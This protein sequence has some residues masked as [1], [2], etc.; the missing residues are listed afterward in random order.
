MDLLKTMLVY[1]TILLTSAVQANPS[2]TPAPPGSIPSPTATAVITAAPTDVPTA[3]PSV[4]YNT[5][6]TGDRGEEV[7]RLQEA[8]KAKGYYTDTV[9]GAYGRNTRKAVEAFQAANGI[10]ADG[11][12]G[13][14]TQRL[15]FEGIVTTNAPAPAAAV[16]AVPQAVVT[17]TYLDET[18]AIVAQRQVTLSVSATVYAQADVLPAG[19]TLTG[20]TTVWINVS[21]G[22]AVPASVIFH[23]TGK[24][25][26]APTQAP[27]QAPSATPAAAKVNVFYVDEDGRLLSSTAVDMVASG[28]V[29]AQAGMVPAGYVLVSQ[30]SAPVTVSGGSASPAS[31]TFIYHSPVTQAPTQAPTLVP[32]QT[33][34]VVPTEVPTDVPTQ[35]PTQIPTEVPVTVTDAPQPEPLATAV[36]IVDGPTQEPFEEPTEEPAEEPAEEPTE[37]PTA[38]P[39]EA[40]TEEPVLPTDAPD[41][42]LATAVPVDEPAQLTVGGPIVINE[43]P[44]YISWCT[45]DGGT[46]FVALKDLADAAGLVYGGDGQGYL[47]VTLN[48]HQVYAQYSSGQIQVVTVDGTLID[49]L[50]GCSAVCVG[51]ALFLSEAVYEYCGVE[52][53]LKGGDLHITIDN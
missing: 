31:V 16:T 1:M 38:E 11:I 24:A 46:V 10:P 40:P 5:L 22:T 34:T 20:S 51:D 52:C 9:D 36:P 6:Y 13:P 53:D 28:V 4:T 25:T 23:C 45:Y 7:R 48:G 47:D 37:E 42:P 29:Y 15:L 30:S 44:S 33:P 35:I 14:V 8:L 41:E 17:V 49:T 43:V 50:P 27:T 39:T 18:N 2:V 19:Y 26:A 21:N 32:T 12:A 3:V